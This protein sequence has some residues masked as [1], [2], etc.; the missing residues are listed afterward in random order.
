MFVDYTFV[1]GVY[2]FIATFLFDSKTK[3]LT[4]H[5]FSNKNQISYTNDQKYLKIF[6]CKYVKF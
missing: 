2:V 1:C 6:L 3:I 5:N 4:F